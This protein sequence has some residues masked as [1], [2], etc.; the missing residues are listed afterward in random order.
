MDTLF[1]EVG[2][3][4]TVVCRLCAHNCH[5]REGKTGNC[6]VR[7][8][9]GG[10]LRTLVGSTVTSINM[11]PVEKKPLYHFH[12]GS[13]VYSVGTP[14]C[15]FSCDFCQNYSISQVPRVTGTVPGKVV[16]PEALVA[17]AKKRRADSVAF[18]YNEPTVFYELVYEVSGLCSVQGLDCIMVS[19]GFMSEDCLASLYR[20]IQ[21]A[22][23]DIKSFR[24]E[25]YRKHCGARLAPVLDSLKVIHRMGWWLEVTT[26]VIP[27]END[28]D[29]E[30]RDIAHFI[31]DELSPDVPWHLSRFHG[32]YNMAS[33]P[34][35]EE[36]HME[37][38]WKLARSEGLHH[39]YLGNMRSSFGST[40][41]CPNCEHSCVTR[42]GFFSHNSLKQGCCPKC[43]TPIPGFWS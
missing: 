21:A 29:E 15:N 4:G 1:W 43:Q 28:S 7:R 34:A 42:Q 38:L 16:A 37:R 2:D 33:H 22:N 9:V 30:I 8:N 3:R 17:D 39:V 24:E 5:I 36:S 26:L 23:I 40:T 27:G 20:R 32:A 13:K 25:F 19:N 35:P 14:G 31:R 12:P 11:D 6:A 41:F 18:T 10:K